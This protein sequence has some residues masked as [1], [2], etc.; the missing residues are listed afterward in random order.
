MD[1]RVRDLDRMLES[2]SPLQQQ[3]RAEHL[4]TCLQAADDGQRFRGKLAHL[5]RDQRI[6]IA[7]GAMVAAD[8]LAGVIEG[9]L[10]RLARP[11]GAG[12]LERYG[13]AVLSCRS[14][15]MAGCAR[16]RAIELVGPELA[17]VDQAHLVATADGVELVAAVYGNVVGY[18]QQ[19]VDA[20]LQDDLVVSARQVCDA[21][22][23][24]DLPLPST[25]A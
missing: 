7:Q 13:H 19:V 8:A 10:R 25:D 22:Y 15:E 20:L 9:R 11:L 1:D 16:W 4:Q 23:G 5:P 18:L 6:D 2:G 14:F 12:D 21:L 17:R 24:R 3:V